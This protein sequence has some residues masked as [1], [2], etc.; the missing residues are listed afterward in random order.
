MKARYKNEK[1]LLFVLKYLRIWDKEKK[2][3]DIHLSSL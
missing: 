1:F 2:L 3:K